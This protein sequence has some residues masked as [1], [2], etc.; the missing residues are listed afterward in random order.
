MDGLFE[1]ILKEP[2]FSLISLSFGVVGVLSVVLS[3]VLYRRAKVQVEPNFYYENIVEVTSLSKNNRKIKI[4]YEDKIV[5]EI[6]TTRVWFWNS[7]R[8]PIR[9]EDIPDR[10][11][12]TISFEEKSKS[13]NERATFFDFKVTKITD[14]GSNFAIYPTSS[15]DKL[16][17]R[18]D[19]IDT[20]QGAVFETQHSGGQFCKLQV[21]G[22]ILGP[23][24]EKK[25]I[26]G[27]HS[28]V[29]RSPPR[30]R[31]V[32]NRIALGFTITS[33]ATV[34]FVAFLIYGSLKSKLLL[35]GEPFKDSFSNVLI[36]H[37]LSREQSIQITNK[38]ISRIQIDVRERAA[39]ITIIVMSLS[40]VSY[41]VT[42]IQSMHNVRMPYPKALRIE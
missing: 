34:L 6:T 8:K 24:R 39:I 31:K 33:F 16:E 25:T 20:K 40:I 42:T 13:G 10:R 7:G 21:D 18:F 29:F 27:M 19:Y 12:L 1:F 35:D 11:P 17:L 26:A 23:K 38:T 9:A 15:P 5:E 22:V 30:S 2:N 28:G 14:P 32:F 4:T 3:F 36:E 37:G 41:V